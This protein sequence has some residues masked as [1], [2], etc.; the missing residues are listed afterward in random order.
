MKMHIHEGGMHC[1]FSRHNKKIRFH[2]VGKSIT[3]TTVKSSIQ[4]DTLAKLCEGLNH[5]LVYYYDTDRETYEEIVFHIYKTFFD[6]Q[7]DRRDKMTAEG[8]ALNQIPLIIKYCQLDEKLCDWI[9][10]YVKDNSVDN[11]NATDATTDITL[12]NE[13][14]NVLACIATA[15]KFSYLHASLLR[16][17]L[18]FEETMVEFVDPLI[19]N[20]V[21]SAEKYFDFNATEEV[22]ED[23]EFDNQE[24]MHSYLDNFIIQ[25]VTKTW[26]GAA[27]ASFKRKFEETGKDTFYYARKHKISILT[28]FKKYLPPAVDDETAMKYA[29]SKEN[30]KKVYYT[31]EKDYK[32]FKFVAKNLAAYIQKTIRNIITTQD[33][34]V[35]ILDVNI[36]DFIIDGTD[37]RSVRKDVAFFEDKY[38]HLFDLRKTTAVG[39]FKQIVD[40]LNKYDL[41]MSF[42]KKFKIGK[43]HIFNQV[44]LHKCLLSL[45]GE[46][47]VYSE[48]FGLYNKFLLLLFYLGVKGRQ[49]LAFM[50][51]TIDLMLLEPS[52]GTLENEAEVEKY[53]KAHD[54]KEISSRA[55][56]SVLKLYTDGNKTIVLG[57]DDFLDILTFVSSPA[58][59]RNLLFPST[60]TN[61]EDRVEHYTSEEY[62]D[63]IRKDILKG[64]I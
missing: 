31:K 33:T 30:A 9:C 4:P 48:T 14:T 5:F 11:I 50:H 34:K 64:M 27:D 19:S 24:E 60:Y 2:V 13:H 52:L 17:N 28:A 7:A 35:D 20:I 63:D 56:C 55:F 18:K 45:T 36:P 8:Y 16:D 62:V 10:R 39:M 43:H 25:L 49:D 51:K 58:R 29:D 22:D 37:E 21:T 57:K 38:R 3:Y 15:I 47:R 46:S 54:V 61:E 59:V 23:E 12:N 41:D 40:E 6:I 53:L 44:I 42:I 26:N 1:F 32:D